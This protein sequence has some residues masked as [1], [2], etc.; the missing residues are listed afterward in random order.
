MAARA[1]AALALL[2]AVV[3]GHGAIITPRSRN[4]WDY[5]VGVNTPKDWPDNRDCTNVTGTDPGD[6]RNG[7]AGFYYS[8]GCSIGCKECDHISGRVQKDICGSGMKATLPD[9]ARSLNLNA[10]AGSPEDIY[11]HNPW[12]A[13][14]AAPVA[15]V[16][17]LAGGTPWLPEVGNAGDYTATKFA[18][19]GYNGSLLPK[20]DTGVRWQLG[21]TAEVTWQ[22]LNNHG[23]GVSEAPP[24]GCCDSCGSSPRSFLLCI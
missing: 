15:D 1:A 18:H 17:G 3:V 4:S 13:P 2:P 11:K 6:C 20:M 7:Q 10:T 14:G 9:Y 21:K 8:Q 22:V 12:R 5:T 19:H 23:G 24:V 16:C